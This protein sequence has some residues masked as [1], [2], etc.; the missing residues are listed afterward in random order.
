MLGRKKRDDLQTNWDAFVKWNPV[1]EKANSEWLFR[2]VT[3]MQAVDSK[4]GSWTCSIYS[5]TMRKLL[6]T[7]I[8]NVIIDAGLENG[9]QF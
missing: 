5:E 7:D 8:R 6:N 4:D 2:D 9:E 1:R 3:S